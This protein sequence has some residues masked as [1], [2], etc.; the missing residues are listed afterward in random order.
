MLSDATIENKL[1]NNNANKGYIEEAKKKFQR[2]KKDL[3]N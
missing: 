1:V 3:E 2:F